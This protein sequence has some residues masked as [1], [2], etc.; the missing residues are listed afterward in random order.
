MVDKKGIVKLFLEGISKN[1]LN[2]IKNGIFRYSQKPIYETAGE[3]IEQVNYILK[4]NPAKSVW[5]NYH[6]SFI[7]ITVI[8]LDFSPGKILREVF[9]DHK[10]LFQ[11]SLFD[12]VN[13][14]NL[15]YFRFLDFIRIYFHLNEKLEIN[16]ELYNSLY[17]EFKEI[18]NDMDGKRYSYT[19]KIPLINFIFDEISHQEEIFTIRLID[20]NKDEIPIYSLPNIL[21]NELPPHLIL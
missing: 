15:P 6:D 3:I 2:W 7:Q 14:L 11:K 4:G 8:G 1:C 18:F 5:Q 19:F 12:I 16:E 20:L 9:L 10:T 13:D 21:E 17:E